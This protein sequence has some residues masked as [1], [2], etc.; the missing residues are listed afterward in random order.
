MREVARRLFAVSVALFFLGGA[1][2]ALLPGALGP[3][4]VGTGLACLVVAVVLR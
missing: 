4:A 1:L 2:L 3:L